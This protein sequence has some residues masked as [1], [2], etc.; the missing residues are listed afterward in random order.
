MLFDK[1]RIGGI[2]ASCRLVRSATF[3]GMAND[4]G[5]ATDRLLDCYRTLAQG[6]V[7]IIITGMIAVGTIEPHQ[8]HQWRADDDR[9]L[10][11]LR[12]IVA[13]VQ[14]NGGKIIAQIV[15]MGSQIALV[16]FAAGRK[17]VS[18]SGVLET[19]LKQSSEALTVAEIGQCVKDYA[20]AAVR[21]K[22]AGFDGI[23][24]HGAHGYLISKFLTPHYNRRT[25]KYGGSLENRARFLLEVLDAIRQE[26]GPD[27]PV[28][29][30]LNCADFMESDGFTF[31][32]SKQVVQ[33]LAQHG[34]SA[35]ELSGGN[36]S[37]IPRQGAIRPIRR[38]K[39]PQ[40]FANY[41]TEIANAT[42]I[43]V[44]VVG[45]FRNPVDMEALLCSSKLAFLSLSR[46]LIKEPALPN[47]WRG[48]DTSPSTC[49]S[50]SRCFNPEGITCVVNQRQKG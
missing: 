27:Y 24:L 4:D 9:F 11:S 39:E 32:E 5:T 25:D 21:M 2:E 33:W 44:G 34:I 19:S 12:K 50:C 28:W 3:E 47:L 31:E 35:V 13:S 43:P 36:T 42:D 46:P 37:S 18:P 45:G 6:G 49:I 1:S 16:K 40:Y 48:G 22:A 8:R 10:P 17:I 30:K 14:E 38:T 41:A 7:G 20:A 26:V 23:Q 29:I 15:L